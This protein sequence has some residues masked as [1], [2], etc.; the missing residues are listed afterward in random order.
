M[1]PDPSPLFLDRTRNWPPWTAKGCVAGSRRAMAASKRGSPSTA[2][3]SFNFGSNDYLALAADPRLAA[4]AIEAITREGWGSGASPLVTG[5]QPLPTTAR[6]AAGPVRS[7]RGGPGLSLRL[8]RQSGDHCRPAGP[9]D[10]VYTDRKEPRQPAG[11]L[12]PLAGR[13]SHVSARRLA[14]TRKAP[15]AEDGLSPP[16]DRHR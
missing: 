9:G 11:R 14:G 8:R 6:R 16:P 13:R 5:L 12:P 7:G 10:V 15:R 2:A 3:R 1:E 4:A